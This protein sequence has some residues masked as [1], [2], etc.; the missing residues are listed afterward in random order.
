MYY[1]YLLCIMYYMYKLTKVVKQNCTTQ[2]IKED[3]LIVQMASYNY[4]LV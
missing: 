2:L 4:S 3:K 1:Y